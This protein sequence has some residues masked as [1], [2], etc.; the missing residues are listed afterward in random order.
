MAV[1]GGSDGSYLLYQHRAVPHASVKGRRK[2]LLTS[3]QSPNAMSET[4]HT[5]QES[6]YELLCSMKER[7]V[8]K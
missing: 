6:L 2:I 1:G 5:Q 7:S 4:C 8:L 3:I